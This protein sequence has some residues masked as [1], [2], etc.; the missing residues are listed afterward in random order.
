MIHSKRNAYNNNYRKYFIAANPVTLHVNNLL[1]SKTKISIHNNYAATLK[2]DGVRYLLYIV[3]SNDEYN[4]SIYLINNNFNLIKTGYKLEGYGGTILEGELISEKKM[5]LLY[6]SLFFK[7]KDVRKSKFDLPLS[8]K[9]E[10]TRLDY[11][12]IF[13]NDL[14]KIDMNDTIITMKKYVY[15]QKNKIF[16][17][18]S[19]LWSTID[20]LDFNV[21]GIIFMPLNDHYP[22]RGGACGNHY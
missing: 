3:K 21:D 11:L 14:T 18:I 12:K 10:K 15:L 4:D 2:A 8:Q 13:L 7:G 1:E 20:K 16:E 5:L 22:S 17:E 9:K 6:D 19:K